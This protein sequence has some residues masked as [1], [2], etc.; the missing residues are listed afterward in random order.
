MIRVGFHPVGGAGWMGGR[1]YL[2]NLLHAISQLEERRIQ[3]VLIAGRG[4][5]RELPAVERFAPGGLMNSPPLHVAGNLSALFGC[6][7]VSRH[8]LR[9]AR[10]DVFSHGEAPLGSR[11]RLPWIYV[12]YDLQ[13]RRLPHLFTP[14]RRAEREWMFRTALAHAAAVVVPTGTVRS[15][16]LAAYG[17]AAERARILRDVAT[18]RLP[19]GELP[20][21]DELVRR[22]GIPRRY[23]HLPNQLWKHKNHALVIDA[24]AEARR[25]EPELTVVATGAGEDPRHPR[26]PGELL[27]RARRLGV[28][29]RHLGLLPHADVMGLMRHSVAVVNPSLFEG[30]S[31]SAGEAASLGKR[32]LLSDIDVH[33]EQAPPRAR[34]FA[35]DDASALAALMIDAW[36]SFDPADD[37]C[38]LADAQRAL[39]DQLRAFAGAYQD[40]VLEV[41]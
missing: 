12:I 7:W 8:W 19:P 11:A 23:V 32:L 17:H 5:G 37:E 21:L 31:L 30:R 3:P 6:N 4:E 29:F 1:S 39:P 24:L 25:H 14:V 9:R 10:V 13:H 27:A 34:Y 22:H 28:R 36:R 33:R 16:L 26:H 40:L 41:S 15:D 38:A 35:P 20:S 18:P 2:W